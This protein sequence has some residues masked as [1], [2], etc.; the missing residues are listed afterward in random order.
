MKKLVAFNWKEN[1]QQIQEAFALADR[2][3]VNAKKYQQVEVV[4]APP[5]VFLLS[6][7][8]RLENCQG[9]A[10]ASQDVSLFDG[11]AHTG[12]ISA[13]MLS[14]IGVTY[15]IV[16][17][18][19][20]R[21]M[22][23]SD[24]MVAKKLLALLDNNIEPILC[25]GETQKDSEDATWKFIETQLQRA[26]PS[27]SASVVIAYEP[28]WAIGGDKEVDLEGAGKVVERIRSFVHE[29]YPQLRVRVVYGGSVHAK[30]VSEVFDCG[31]DGVLVGSASLRE[32]DVDIII[33]S[34]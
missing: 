34:A 3:E 27:V 30:N 18:S 20:R 19:E 11:G 33:A 13:Q 21:A 8:H 10:C 5:A 9:V 17:H 22:G 26:L 6:I 23:E 16:G 7:A 24:E 15:C 4:V 29:T 1:P 14:E 32:K 31:V 25:V 28:V 12:E 2:V